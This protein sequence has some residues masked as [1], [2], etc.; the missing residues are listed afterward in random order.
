MQ[1]DL[2][3]VNGIVIWTMVQFF[4]GGETGRKDWWVCFSFWKWNQ[5]YMKCSQFLF[6]AYVRLVLKSFPLQFNLHKKLMLLKGH[7]YLSYFASREGFSTYLSFEGRQEVLSWSPWWAKEI[8]HI[9][10]DPAEERA[11]ITD[12]GTFGCVLAEQ[13]GTVCIKKL[14]EKFMLPGQT[15]FYN[16]VDPLVTAKAACY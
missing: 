15:M 3:V 10:W 5:W 4:Q 1:I 2:H 7:L 11:V 9:C 13:K 8:D 16:L 12:D 14:N 6:T